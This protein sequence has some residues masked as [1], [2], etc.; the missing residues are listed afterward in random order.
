[1]AYWKIPEEYNGKLAFL[2]DNSTRNQN[3]IQKVTRQVY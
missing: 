3:G 1:M 2:R